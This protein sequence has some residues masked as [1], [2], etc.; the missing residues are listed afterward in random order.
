LIEHI[1]PEPVPT[2][3][4]EPEPVPTPVPEPEPV[5]TPQVDVAVST[6]YSGSPQTEHIDSQLPVRLEKQGMVLK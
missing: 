6:E 2:P 5:P 1:S 4:P 3:V